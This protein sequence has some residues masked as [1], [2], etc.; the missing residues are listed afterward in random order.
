MRP[1][2]ALGL[3]VLGAVLLLAGCGASQSTGN[4]GTSTATPKATTSKPTATTEVATAIT[5]TSAAL[6]A[7]VNDN[8][9]YAD[10]RE[11]SEWYIYISTSASG[12]SPELVAEN[13]FTGAASPSGTVTALTPN[14]TYYFQVMVKNSQGTV[15]GAWVGFTTTG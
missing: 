10:H 3:A 13:G 4:V 7:S 1:R 8:G 9:L 11:T 14:T 5:P 15:D 2:K 12:S 6:N